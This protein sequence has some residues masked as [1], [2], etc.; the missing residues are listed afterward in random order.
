MSQ[1]LVTFL[2]INSFV[3]QCKHKRIPPPSPLHPLVGGRAA[4]MGGAARGKTARAK[5]ALHTSGH[6]DIFI[7]LAALFMSIT[8]HTGARAGAVA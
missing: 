5:G 6:V 8:V 3:E 7:S 1:V 4:A 2:F